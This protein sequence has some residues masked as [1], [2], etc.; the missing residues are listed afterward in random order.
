MKQEL[1]RVCTACKKTLSI[2]QFNCKSTGYPQ[3][4][5]KDCAYKY[6]TQHG[7]YVKEHK[8]EINAWRRKRYLE[9]E[10][11]RIKY[12]EYK[13]TPETRAKHAEYARLK[14]INNPEECRARDRAHYQKTPAAHLF[15]SVKGRAKR[16]ELPFDLD[17]SDIVIP[18]VCP[19][20]GIL[21]T[22]CAE[23]RDNSPSVD[24]IIP[25]LGYVKGNVVVISYRAN[26]IKNDASLAELE[27][28]VAYVQQHKAA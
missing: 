19:V 25:E 24:R 22:P 13:A 23:N 3:K 4:R 8:E 26:R 20:L 14:R 12:A 28:V 9:R 18:D 5:C 17:K 11:V 16:Q 21:I 10:D 7:Q 1:T 6:A 15:Y 2:D 27:L